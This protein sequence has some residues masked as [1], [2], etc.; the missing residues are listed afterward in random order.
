MSKC[1]T[2]NFT[3]VIRSYKET[4]TKTKIKTERKTEKYDKTGISVVILK[5]RGKNY[6]DI[7][8][9][10]EKEPSYINKTCVLI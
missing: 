4:G 7:I 5:Q 8:I 2:N 3:A 10:F 1:R 9:I 6:L